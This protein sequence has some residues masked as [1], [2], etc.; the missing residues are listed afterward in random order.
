MLHI[1]ALLGHKKAERFGLLPVPDSL[2]RLVFLP[3][4]EGRYVPIEALLLEYADQ[5]FS[6]YDMLE[7]TVF[8]VTR[9]ADI[10]PDDEP[11]DG[12]TDFRKKM[13]KLLRQRR[14]LAVVRVELTRPVSRH[15]LEFFLRRFDVEE[16]QIFLSRR[17]P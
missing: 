14:R 17:L 13:E 15:F 7:K 12:E 2:P 16:E 9:N 10:N 5:V 3:G 1:G 4:D 11:F 8:C 6:M